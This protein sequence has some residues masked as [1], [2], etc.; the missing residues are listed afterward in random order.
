MKLLVGIAIIGIIVMI[1]LA[2]KSKKNDRLKFQK[3]RIWTPEE[4]D[5]IYKLIING[6]DSDF[7][8]C[9]EFA[10]CYVDKLQEIF[11]DPYDLVENYDKLSDEIKFMI[12]DMK[13]N[14]LKIYSCHDKKPYLKNNN[15]SFLKF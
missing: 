4:V 2:I 5:Y 13:N 1:I 9:T 7:I 6:P 10:K 11:D 14:C 3:R 12:S 8:G 15:T